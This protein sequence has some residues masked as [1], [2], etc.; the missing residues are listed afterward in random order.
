MVC[1]EVFVGSMMLSKTLYAL[2]VKVLSEAVL[3]GRYAGRNLVVKA[4]P[5]RYKNQAVQLANTPQRYSLI[6]IESISAAS[7]HSSIQRGLSRRQRALD[8]STQARAYAHSHHASDP[9]PP[10]D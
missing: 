7:I 10:P 3:R 2:G 4:L 9:T 8:Y 5:S 1:F 6:A